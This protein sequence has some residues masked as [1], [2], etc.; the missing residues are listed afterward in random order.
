MCEGGDKEACWEDM[1]EGMMGCMWYTEWLCG[2]CEGTEDCPN[3]IKKEVEV[4]RDKQL[5]I[6]DI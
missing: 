5:T 1:E 6:F 2:D 4:K 3:Y